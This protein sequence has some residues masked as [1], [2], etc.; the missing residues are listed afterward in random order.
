MENTQSLQLSLI[1]GFD[2]NYLHACLLEVWR[3]R[4]T[5]GERES[6]QGREGVRFGLLLQICVS[7]APSKRMELD[8]DTSLFVEICRLQFIQLL[9]LLCVCVCVCVCVCERERDRVTA[10]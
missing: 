9:F 6:E 10:S 7:V 1:T 3:E 8:E 2:R 5:E 4:E